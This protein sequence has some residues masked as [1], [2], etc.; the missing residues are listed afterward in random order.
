MRG[1]DEEA[2]GGFGL[3]DADE[4]DGVK[5]QGVVM[6]DELDGRGCFEDGDRALGG[7]DLGE[8]G[9]EGEALVGV[10]F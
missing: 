2:F 9:G 8:A 10:E 3:A 5:A 6:F 4:L 7:G 1:A